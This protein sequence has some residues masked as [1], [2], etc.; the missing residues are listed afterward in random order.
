M[1]PSDSGF[2]PD[3]AIT[4]GALFGL[5]HSRDEAGVVVIP[6]PFD[7]TASY[8][9]GSARGPEAIREASAQTDLHDTT[10]G[11]TWRRGIF[12]EHIPEDIAALSEQTRALSSPIIAKGGPD[13]RDADA[14]DRIDAAGET[15]RTHVR[16]R[17]SAALSEGRF[18][19]VVGGEHSVS[20]GAI[21]A[22]SAG[23]PIGVLQIDAHA[24]LREAYEGLTYSHA[25]VIRNVLELCPN[26]AFVSQ[27]GIRDLSRGER[28]YA[29]SSG[30][31]RMYHDDTIAS[32]LAT[33]LLSDVIPS[34]II[35]GLPERVYVTVDIDGLDPSL[36]P[37]TGTP[38]PGGLTWRELTLLLR[39]LKRSGK[40]VVGADLVEV[41][42]GP[43]E[44]DAN[45]GARVLYR[46]CALAPDRAR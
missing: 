30:R 26:V 13:E 18:P 6:V 22:A 40:T 17:V 45:V 9:T 1:S 37:S 31:V 2:D 44:W 19:I 5:P 23:E 16:D 15:V 21:E 12:M 14:I 8:G 35:A 43:T 20:L 25:S 39:K 4:N 33:G 10:F 42:P 7:A 34:E 46:L 27:V 29:A 36:C 3:G 32:R 28:D 41:A 38:V 24:D 11:D